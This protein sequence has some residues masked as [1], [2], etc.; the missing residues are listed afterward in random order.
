MNLLLDTHILLW[1]AARPEKLSR[2]TLRLFDDPDNTLVFS[3]ASLW[4]IVIKQS[5]GRDDF[6]VN[7]R[8][9]RRGLLDNGYNELSV[10][11]I[12]ALALDDL[13]PLHKDPFDRMLLAQS[14]VEGFMLLTADKQILQYPGLI[15]KA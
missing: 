3:A 5:L 11:S 10:T 14:R 13:P 1:A 12:H 9:L 8:Q 7:A 6:D 4:E 2:K 15:Q